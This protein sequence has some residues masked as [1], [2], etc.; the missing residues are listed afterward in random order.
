[1]IAGF[2]SDFD[3]GT[4]VQREDAATETFQTCKSYRMVVA[5]LT[6]YIRCGKLFSTLFG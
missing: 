5:D 3:M 6:V 2:D 4:A 1:M